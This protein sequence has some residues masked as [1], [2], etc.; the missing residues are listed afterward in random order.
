[1][2]AKKFDK[3]MSGKKRKILVN[4]LYDLGKYGARAQYIIYNCNVFWIAKL[5]GS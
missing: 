1:M 3:M 5:A 2:M 4:F